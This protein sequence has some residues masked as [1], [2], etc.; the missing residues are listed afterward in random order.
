MLSKLRI[1][2]KLLLA[3]GAVLFLLIL[4]SCGAYYAMVRQNDSLGTIVEQRAARLRDTAALVNSAQ[5][6]HTDVYQLLTWL[7]ASFSERR[8]KALASVIDSDQADTR[9]RLRQLAGMRPST[10]SPRRTAPSTSGSP[11]G[12]RSS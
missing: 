1:G 7:G 3:P 4:V 2:P 6:A 12:R 11:A 9:R 8:V 10:A 5:R